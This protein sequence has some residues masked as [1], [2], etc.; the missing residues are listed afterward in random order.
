MA[1]NLDFVVT[2]INFFGK[3]IAFNFSNI[4]SAYH[5]QHILLRT[6]CKSISHP[7]Y[8]FRKRDGRNIT[9]Q[10]LN[11]SEEGIKI[12]DDLLINL[13]YRARN[14]YEY[15]G[16]VQSVI[17]GNSFWVHVFLTH[18]ATFC[19]HCFRNAEFYLKIVG[20]RLIVMPQ[21]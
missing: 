17:C 12:R 19:T 9:K 10:Y 16:K 6:W 14:N 21:K 18:F 20:P 3:C 13:K 2:I 5:Y 4:A 11:K 7:A 15:S 1:E 8:L